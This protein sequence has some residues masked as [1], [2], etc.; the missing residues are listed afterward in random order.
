MHVSVGTAGGTG[1]L[2]M[3][4]V[5]GFQGKGVKNAALMD[6]VLQYSAQ[7]GNLS[8]VLMGDFNE[9]LDN[10]WKLPQMMK[11]ALLGGMM[12]DIDR[13]WADQLGVPT[14]CAYHVPGGGTTRIDGILADKSTAATV[15][16][17]KSCR[18][19]TYRDTT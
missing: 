4:L 9:S 6:T 1:M 12:V 3:Q 2:E 19:C 7:V 14:S 17:F 18:A 11:L 15:K 8:K 13:Q 10:V 5:Y 16:S